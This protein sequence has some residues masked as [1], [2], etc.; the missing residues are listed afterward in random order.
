M[1][2]SDTDLERSDRLWLQESLNEGEILHWAGKPVPSF[3]ANGAWLFSLFSLP[4]LFIVASLT[5]ESLSG[6][7][8]L[9]VLL[10]LILLWCIGLGLFTAPWWQYRQI[11][12]TVYALTDHKALILTPSLFGR[13][14]VKTYPLS[15]NL[16][17]ERIQ[18]KNG[19]G[20]LIFDYEKRHNKHGTRLVGVGFLRLANIQIVEERLQSLLKN[21]PDSLVPTIPEPTYP[22]ARRI[23][24][25]LAILLPLLFT[26]IGAFFLYRNIQLVTEGIHTEGTVLRLQTERVSCKTYYYPVIRFQD[27][28]G[29]VHMAQSH[30]GSTSSTW[31]RGERI[32]LYYQPDNPEQMVHDEFLSLWLLP[33]ISVGFGLLIFF[34]ALWGA[35]HKRRKIE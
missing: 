3:F 1:L 2:L 5:V 16:V 30:F 9:P 34:P 26:S 21:A 19:S 25:I 31:R 27:Q 14:R 29:R 7:A 4:W 12:H 17:K 22:A 11:S 28:Q 18:H 24:L 20:D 32:K 15:L 23:H 35:T 8:P 6:E 10:F 13:R 33:S